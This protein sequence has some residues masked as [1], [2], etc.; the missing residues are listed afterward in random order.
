MPKRK[1]SS[2]DVSFGRNLAYFRKLTGMTQQ[3]VADRLNINRTTYT[4]YET[5][6]S[7]PGIEILKRIADVLEV[8]V[9][10]L[11]SDEFPEGMQ[12]A[13]ALGGT[14]D[15]QDKIRRLRRQIAQ[16]SPKEMEQLNNA[17]AE[18]GVLSFGKQDEEP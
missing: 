13:D 11:V 5:G 2:V 16:L 9:S 7:E 15:M 14:A 6:A 4:K 12:V 10:T 18:S 17:L 1:I 8:D 3:Q